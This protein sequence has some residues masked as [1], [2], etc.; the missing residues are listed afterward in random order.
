M[1]LMAI[2]NA[3]A[4]WGTRDLSGATMYTSFEPCPM[5]CGDILPSG[6]RVAGDRCV[7]ELSARF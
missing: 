2:R 5:C 6:I 7:V 3:A 1:I 4:E